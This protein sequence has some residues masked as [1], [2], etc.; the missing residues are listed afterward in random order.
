MFPN[1]NLVKLRPGSVNEV[2]SYLSTASIAHFACH[3]QQNIR[4]PLE[5][6]LFLQDGHLKGLSDHAAIHAER[7]SSFLSACETAMG[8]ENLPDEVIHI[9]SALLFAV[10]G[11][12]SQL[13]GE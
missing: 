6:A 5:S 9:G 4:D 3:G 13:C 10:S 1:E 2:I 12:L 11:E 8:D 7:I